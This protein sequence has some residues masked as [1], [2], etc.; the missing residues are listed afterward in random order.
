MRLLFIG[1]EIRHELGCAASLGMFGYDVLYLHIGFRYRPLA[2]RNVCL[3]YSC[4]KIKTAEIHS[5]KLPQVLLHTKSVIPEDI[6]HYNP[7]IVFSTPSVPTYVGRYLAKLTDSPL[8]LRIWGVRANKLMDHLLHGKN[9]SEIVLFPASILH[10]MVQIYNSK[11]AVTLDVSTMKF[12]RKI[13]PS[14]RK[15]KLVYPTYAALYGNGNDYEL[16]KIKELI[17]RGDYIFGFVT[18]SKTGSVFR[19]EQQ[20]LFKILY[21]IAKRCPEINVVIAGG[22]LDEA[23]RKFGF[24]SMPKNL[25][26][27]GSGISDNAIKALYEHAKLVVIPVFSRSVSNRLLEA[28]FY[29]RPVLTNSVALEL[30]PELRECT[31][32]SD[33]YNKYPEIIKDLLRQDHVLEELHLKVKMIWDK[34][35]SSRVQA[36]EMLKAI[37]EIT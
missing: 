11:A 19:L 34:L 16:L 31:I 17:E 1:S 8:V 23:R 27:A 5:L 29:R 21:V 22:T 33:D 35:F 10:N 28:L 25:L 37:K 30:H 6:L 7:D 14:A 24:S 18:M 20:P 4:L 12:L 3:D 2:W 26:F 32:V 15:I 9:Y 36:V 13:M